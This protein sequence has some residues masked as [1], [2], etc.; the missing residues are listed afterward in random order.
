[1]TNDNGAIANQYVR[2]NLMLFIAFC[3]LAF[4]PIFNFYINSKSHRAKSVDYTSITV[5]I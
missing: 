1:M 4:G 5:Q 3:V 2:F